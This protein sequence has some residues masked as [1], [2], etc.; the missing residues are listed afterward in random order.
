MSRNRFD[1]FGS[2]Q[3]MMTQYGQFQQNPMAF[4]SQKGLNIPQQYQNDPNGAIQYLMNNGK[5]TQQ[6]YNWASQFASMAFPSNK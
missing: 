2:R 1:P 3:G 5:L 6:Q 4:L